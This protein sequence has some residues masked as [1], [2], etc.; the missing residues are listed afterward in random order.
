MLSAITGIKKG[1]RIMT[2]NESTSLKFNKLFLT[3]LKS[4]L[5]QYFK[6][7]KLKSF[8]FLILITL[9]II[10]T[11]R[12]TVGFNMF[13]RDFFNALS[14]F[15]SKEIMVQIGK[16]SFFIALLMFAEA[17]NA[18]LSGL[19]AIK[20]RRLATEN[21]VSRWLKH[22]KYYFLKMEN[23]VDNPDQ[24]IA[25]DLDQFPVSTLGLYG[26]FFNSVLT[27]LTFGITLWQSSVPLQ[28]AGSAYH[29]PGFFCWCA[30]TYSIVGTWITNLL[31]GKLAGLN[32]TQQKLNANY[33]LGL[34]KLQEASEE[35]ALYNGEPAEQTKLSQSFL[36]VLANALSINNI[37]KRLTFFAGGYSHTGM[38]LGL[39][40]TAPFYLNKQIDMGTMML[41]A[42]GFTYTIN[43]FSIFVQCFQALAD[44]RATLHRIAEF[45]TTLSQQRP[46]E[47]TTICVSR[48]NRTDV[49]IR[50]LT[51]TTPAG[52]N[53]LTGINLHLLPATSYI[54]RGNTGAGK[55]TLFKAIADLWSHGS[56]SIKLP[57]A[58]KIL[59]L[60][61]R[62]YLFHGTLK[63]NLIYPDNEAFADENLITMLRE[64]GLG[65]FQSKL[66]TVMDWSRTLSLGQQQLLG[67]AR[68]LLNQPNIIFLDEAT[69]A[70]DESIEAF[71][72]TL[73]KNRLP[74]AIILSI[75][76][77]SSLN[78]FHDNY[79]M[80]RNSALKFDKVIA[81]EVE[82]ALI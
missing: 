69:S 58:A 55:S 4:V 82:E 75:G 46:A 18:Y 19:L 7:E 79:L 14:A 31:G 70:L 64:V 77:R 68:I 28:I 10:V 8:M 12:A 44:W 6:T 1:I 49:E 27:I 63:A 15:N 13:N 61:Q 26:I 50:D 43:S 23:K 60:P 39:I 29:I 65:E 56:G 47:N 45:D 80:V 35:I 53:L 54:I 32:F 21:F 74:Q 33:R 59:F 57:Q 72:Y 38:V 24:R 5:T 67:F 81:H 25:S 11:V 42:G 66:E 73:L 71:I 30:L 51:I 37:K 52:R 41:V 36:T 9:C 16:L 40:I 34:I 20:W 62:P 48:H 76:H 3:E 2:N 17:Y 22:K 78:K